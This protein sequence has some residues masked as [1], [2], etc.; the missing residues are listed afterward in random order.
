MVLCSLA[1]MV[2]S[3]C[4]SVALRYSDRVGFPLLT[5]EECVVQLYQPARLQEINRVTPHDSAPTD[6]T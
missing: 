2:T 3:A 5:Q 4:H 1:Y 6:E